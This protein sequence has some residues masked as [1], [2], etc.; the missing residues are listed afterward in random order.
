LRNARFLNRSVHGATVS[1]SFKVYE[2]AERTLVVT[3]LSQRALKER[4]LAHTHVADH[5]DRMLHGSEPSGAQG[6]G[7]LQ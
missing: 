1:V 5:H 3:E 7:I 2:R 6:A 4:R